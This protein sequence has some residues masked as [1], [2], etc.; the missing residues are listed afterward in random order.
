MRV[1]VTGHDGYIGTVLVPLFQAAGHEVVGLDS[2]LFSDCVFGD[3]VEPVPA[4]RTDIRDVTPADL[5]G[6]DAVV[7]L[8]ALSN[9]PLGDL[10]PACTYDI[11]HLGA[12]GVATA[13]KEAGVERFLM[14]SSCSLYGAHGDRP[15][16]ESAEFLPVTPYGE[17]KVLSERDISA[18]A[19]DSFSPTFLRNATAYGMS[20][21]LRGDLVVNNLVAYAVT[22]GEVRL[23]SDGTPWRP[24]VHI[25]DIARAFLAIA[26]APRDLVHDQAFNVGQTT[27]NYQIRQVAEIVEQVVPGSRVTFADDAGP[28]KRNY[29]VDCDRIREVLPAFRPEW[30]VLRGAEELYNAYLRFG[31]TEELL[32][33]GR[34]Q[35]IAR[36]REL[37]DAGEITSDLRWQSV[38]A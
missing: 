12:V 14:S 7:H 22:I 13:A 3:D 21:R 37:L 8:A 5:E 1:L 6:F 17:S 28:D 24:L 25:E 15:I 9:D 20:P 19:D 16:D 2:F 26:E 4:I 27:E 33:G 29:R 10:N 23:K 18:L 30:T 35:R 38:P 11:N 32:H 31:L 34:L 36:I